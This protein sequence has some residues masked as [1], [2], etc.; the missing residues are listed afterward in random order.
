MPLN[1]FQYPQTG[2]NFISHTVPMKND[3]AK[4]DRRIY[5]FILNVLST[6][7]NAKLH[8]HFPVRKNIEKKVNEGLMNPKIHNFPA[9]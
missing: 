1:I 2:W 6:I 8:Q 7:E 3:L 4:G 9:Q 5:N